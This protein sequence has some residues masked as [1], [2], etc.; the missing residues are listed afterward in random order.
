M[1]FNA[2]LLADLQPLPHSELWVGAGIQPLCLF[3]SLLPKVPARPNRIEQRNRTEEN[4]TGHNNHDVLVRKNYYME[5]NRA[6]KCCCKS[7]H[8]SRCWAVL[9]LVRGLFWTTVHLRL[10]KSDWQ[11]KRSIILVAALPP[12]L[13][14][15]SIENLHISPS[16]TLES[17]GLSCLR[18]F[19]SNWLDDL[20]T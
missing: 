20:C 9:S 11:G 12:S 3:S 17:A 14:D 5:A 15:L 4:K 8:G 6:H 7:D 16:A 1:L 2:L 10:L 19:S 18:S 13:R